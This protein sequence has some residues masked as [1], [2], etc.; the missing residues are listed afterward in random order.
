MAEFDWNVLVS[1]AASA[2]NLL[3]AF[4]YAEKI[5]Q[6]VTKAEQQ[7]QYLAGEYS[8][9]NLIL[10]ETTHQIETVTLQIK[11][12]QEEASTRLQKI[13][14]D[15]DTTHNITMANA[16]AEWDSLNKSIE[17][18]KSTLIAEQSN[19]E[20]VIKTL[21]KELTSIETQL[22]QAKEEYKAFAAILTSNMAK[23]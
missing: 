6:M 15:F 9:K 21:R 5:F 8:E 12:Q 11:T 22:T 18:T 1:N 23:V 2:A 20:Q 4:E 3:R 13:K 16:K 10:E 7:L 17:S 14:D 19:L